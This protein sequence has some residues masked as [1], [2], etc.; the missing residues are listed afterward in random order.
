[1]N[2]MASGLLITDFSP[3]GRLEAQSY[4]GRGGGVIVAAG[5]FSGRGK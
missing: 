4:S 5:V 1:M 2:A 3:G